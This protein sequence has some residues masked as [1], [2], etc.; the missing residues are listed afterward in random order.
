MSASDDRRAV[1]RMVQPDG[2][3]TLVMLP[4]TLSIGRS[5]DNGLV[6]EDPSVSRHHAE[7][8]FN[9]EGHVLYDRNSK[10]GSF[11]NRERAVE[12]LLRPGD[13]ITLGRPDGLRLVYELGD[14][15][16]SASDDEVGLS[17]LSVVGDGNSRYLRTMAL[18][19]KGPREGPVASRLKALY[20]IASSTF[21]SRTVEGLCRNLLDHV[22]EVLP[23]ERGWVLLKK[24]GNQE[25]TVA[26]HATFGSGAGV[27]GRPSRTIVARVCDENVALLSMNAMADSRFSA[28]ESILAQSIRSVICA[29]LSSARR[30][31]GVCYFDNSAQRGAFDHEQLEFL[32]AA[33]RQAG[34]A[35]ENLHLIEDQRRALD[36][37]IGTL[38]AAIDARDVL[39]AGHS[40]R[41]ASNASA[42]AAFLGSGPE[43]VRLVQV[44]GLL[45][46]VGKIG[47][48]DDVLLKSGQL[49]A[50]EFDHMKE[51]PRRTFQIL[52]RIFFTEELR[53]LPAIAAAH[54][55]NVDG[56]GYPGGLSRDEIPFPGRIIAIADVFDA[57]TSKRHYR[58]PMAIEAT[59]E[60]IEGMV[61]TKF[62]AE[63]VDVFKKFVR[64]GRWTFSEGAD[65]TA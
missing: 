58:D 45:H 16:A 47:I 4:S 33:S 60:V 38:T 14:G 10:R 46:D 34:V 30:V 55:E 31:W 22:A 52:S 11:V 57:L 35:L 20:E 13:V 32:M 6:I 56:S 59:L 53:D 64:E 27:Q 48:R 8:V 15:S 54:H 43:E 19:L 49:T 18:D 42:F 25:T 2:G 41:V 50:E 36:S 9:G 28:Q 44:A 26:A 65:P 51:H 29:P 24:E 21:S 61:G 1:L 62:D 7:V 37:F 23:C 17:V 3:S 5:V 63:M 40:A 12:R 39:T